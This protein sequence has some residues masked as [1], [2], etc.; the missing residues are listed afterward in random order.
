MTD[1]IMMKNLGEAAHIDG[2]AARFA[3]IEVLR[4]VGWLRANNATPNPLH[5]LRLW[6]H[7]HAGLELFLPRQGRCFGVAWW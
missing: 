7:S 3:D 6:R 2:L 1:L 4:F 5:A